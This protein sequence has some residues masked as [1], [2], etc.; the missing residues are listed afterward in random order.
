MK[1]R[2][3]ADYCA[4][5]LTP[6]TTVSASGISPKIVPTEASYLAP[7]KTPDMQLKP[8]NQTDSKLCLFHPAKNP[9]S[10]HKLLST[11]TPVVTTVMSNG[12]TPVGEACPSCFGKI[13]DIPHCIT[14]GKYWNIAHIGRI[15]WH[16]SHSAVVALVRWGHQSFPA[17]GNSNE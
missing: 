11:N 15:K 13:I 17:R 12:N 5:P 3:W 14:I 9:Q 10:Q 16:S 2:T 4:N 8:E 1:S 6:N 7:I